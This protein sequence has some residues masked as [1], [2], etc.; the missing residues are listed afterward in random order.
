MVVASLVGAAAVVYARRW[1]Q[2]PDANRWRA[3]SFA[4]ACTTILAAAQ[5]PLSALGEERL[6]L[7]HVVM[8][9]LLIHVAPFFV[10]RAI[11]PAILGPRAATV[12]RGLG[13]LPVAV[14]LVL[15]AGVAYA[16][17]LPPV[18][19]AAA[20]N[21]W[22]AGLQHA[23]FVVVGV[24]AWQPI[25]GHPDLRVPLRGLTAFL[26]VT[27]DELLLGALGIVLTWAP[28]PLYDVYVDAP[29][30]WGLSADTDQMLAGAVLTVVEEGPMAIALAVVFIRMLERD[31][32]EL[33][34]QERALDARQGR[35]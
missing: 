33:R 19:D 18:F 9:I 7:A 2:A 22:L 11:T 17:H 10:V 1:R 27:G 31:E 5:G 25:G 32:R 15:L 4:A 21:A 35:R 28:G 13:G 12:A 29:R 24:I 26:Y 23:S 3:L 20:S 8:L 14:P 16:W 6:A 34:A 30:T